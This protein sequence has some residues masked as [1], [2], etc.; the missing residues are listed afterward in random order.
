MNHT[1][2]RSNIIST[3]HFSCHIS[4]IERITVLSLS[5]KIQSSD[6]SAVRILY[7]TLKNLYD[8][9]VLDIRDVAEFD[10]TLYSILLSALAISQINSTEFIIM[11]SPRNT[12]RLKMSGVAKQFMIEFCD[13]KK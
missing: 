3:S 5:G 10:E 12:E 2:Y 1:L 7:Q 6:R 11:A 13:C 9:C 8:V 4:A